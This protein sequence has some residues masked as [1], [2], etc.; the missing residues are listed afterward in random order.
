MVEC[1]KCGHVWK[2][3]SDDV[4]RQCPKCW[5]TKVKKTSGDDPKVIQIDPTTGTMKAY[6]Y[7]IDQSL[8]TTDS[9]TFAEVAVSD[10][11]MDNNWRFTE[12][13]DHGVVLKS[14]EGKK[15]RVKLEEIE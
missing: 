10:L 11:V 1:E 14:P 2:A 3:R 4:P 15:Y 7:A 6:P 8:Q 13:P 12:H 9:V 5:S